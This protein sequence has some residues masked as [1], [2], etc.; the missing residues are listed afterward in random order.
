MVQ[1]NP[2][3]DVQVRVRRKQKKVKVRKAVNAEQQRLW[4]AV[5]ARPGKQ[6]AATNDKA[7]NLLCKWNKGR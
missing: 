3:F 7:V 6:R 5:G 1:S 2:E 4:W